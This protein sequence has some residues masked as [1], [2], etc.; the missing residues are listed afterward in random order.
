MWVQPTSLRN[1]MLFCIGSV[2]L[3]AAVLVAWVSYLSL[4]SVVATAKDDQMQMLAASYAQST[5]VPAMRNIA[6]P[7]L[8]ARGIFV[9]QIWS[10]KGELISASVPDLPIPMQNASGFSLVRTGEADADEW[11]VYS[12]PFVASADPMDAQGLR[13]QVALS[14]EYLRQIVVDR[15]FKSVLPIALLLPLSFAA[16]WLLV[17]FSS[18]SL[19]SVAMD[20]SRQDERNLSELSPTRV[21][22]E[23]APLVVAYNSLLARLRRAF[24]SQER[25]VQDAAHELRTPIAAVSLQLENL[26]CYVPPGEASE[27]FDQLEGGVARSAH[28]IEQ[29]LRLSRQESETARPFD[30]GTCEV[31]VA[32]VLR[33]SVGQL[34]GHADKRNIDVG[35]EGRI[36]VAVRASESDLRSIFD[37]LIGNA[38]RY[39]GE[40]GIVDVVLHD[41]D[42]HAVVDVIDSGPGIPAEYLDRA[43]DRFF[44]VPG[45]DASGS[46]LGL[47]IAQVAAERN[48]LHV[49]LINRHQDGASSARDLAGLI[50]R[51]HLPGKPTS[52]Q[53]MKNGPSRFRR[54]RRSRQGAAHG[55]REGA[56]VSAAVPAEDLGLHR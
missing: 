12:G 4:S 18:R 40:D 38:V 37:N 20:V 11:R 2:H 30:D 14:T 42:G 23:I 41:L 16:L 19:R 7:D 33:E 32:A 36:H 6:Q 49:E 21:P 39:S 3:L 25:F 13:V 9:I 56:L 10:S 46:G 29:L 26:R 34:M 55:G 52:A 1:R 24:S 54:S 44:R 15:A 50:A 27:Q 43:F 45:T 22:D 47:S 51:V 53:S 48:G 31:D 8:V 17:G 28:L 5:S 35:F